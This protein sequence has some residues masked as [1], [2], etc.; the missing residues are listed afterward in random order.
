ML[1]WPGPESHLLPP[2]PT[3]HPIHVFSRPSRSTSAP[4]L[5]AFP[6]FGPEMSILI[7]LKKLKRM[8]V[9]FFFFYWWIIHFS[10]RQFNIWFT[11][12]IHLIL[13]VFFVY[14]YYTSELNV[15]CIWGVRYKILI[16]IINTRDKCTEN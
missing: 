6:F 3:P 15:Y 13:Q 7:Y 14:I 2:T 8:F 4:G 16:S 9:E 1:Y 11:F 10:S 5:L 12:Y